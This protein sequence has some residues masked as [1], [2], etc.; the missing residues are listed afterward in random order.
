MREFD[1]GEERRKRKSPLPIEKEIIEESLADIARDS[2]F[3]SDKTINFL[4]G[5]QGVEL[6]HLMSLITH[7][8]SKYEDCKLGDAFYSSAVRNAHI[9][10]GFVYAVRLIHDSFIAK[11]VDFCGLNFGEWEQMEKRFQ[12][13]E[14]IINKG[15]DDDFASFVS[16]KVEKINKIDFNFS[17]G[18]CEMSKYREDPVSFLHGA[19]EAYLF[20]N[21]ALNRGSASQSSSVSL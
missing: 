10:G 7:N 21:E 5:R 20:I 3:A 12:E 8:Y 1:I 13:V 14:A 4:Y 9:R 6:N 19:T 11:N 17:N 15:N 18:I 16:E 2:G